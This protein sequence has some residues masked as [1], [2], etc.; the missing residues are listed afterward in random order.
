MREEEKIELARKV[1]PSTKL[2][3]SQFL[4]II[5]EII[6]IQKY[7]TCIKFEIDED[8]IHRVIWAKTVTGRL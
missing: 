4:E 8:Y 5:N 6:D 3:P 7:G 2:S 1:A